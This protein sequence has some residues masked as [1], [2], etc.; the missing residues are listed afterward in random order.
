MRIV[1]IL[2]RNLIKS[3]LVLKR[4]MEKIR[5]S[6]DLLDN[7]C[8]HWDLVWDRRTPEHVMMNSFNKIPPDS[9]TI[10]MSRRRSPAAIL[11]GRTNV[12]G[13]RIIGRGS[14]ANSDMI[15]S[16]AKNDEEMHDVASFF[17]G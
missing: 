12:L 5:F 16:S 11:H 13:M 7:G 17:M 4:G 1:W 6:I 14:R 9:L 10:F 8:L 3:L 2:F 15:Y